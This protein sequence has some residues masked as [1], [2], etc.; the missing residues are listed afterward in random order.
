MMRIERRAFLKRV[1]VGLGGAIGLLSA[2]SKGD[3]FTKMADAPESALSWMVYETNQYLHVVFTHLM[4]LRKRRCYVVDLEAIREA[5]HCVGAVLSEY[6]KD[7]HV[8][9]LEFRNSNH[10]FGEVKYKATFLFGE[11]ILVRD[12]ES[13]FTFMVTGGPGDPVWVEEVL[14]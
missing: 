8:I 7:F 12:Y 13:R 4:S 11:K 5:S 14:K 9:N 2:R 10:T 3:I 6:L 1:F